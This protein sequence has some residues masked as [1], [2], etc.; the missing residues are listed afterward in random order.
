MALWLVS[1][2]VCKGMKREPAHAKNT[3]QKNQHFDQLVFGLVVIHVAVCV[4]VSRMSGLFDDTCYTCIG[5]AF[6]WKF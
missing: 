4:R 1:S 6:N 3:H 5:I 2:H